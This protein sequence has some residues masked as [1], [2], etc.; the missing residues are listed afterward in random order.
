MRLHP[1]AATFLLAGTLSL[2]AQ[3]PQAAAASASHP[4]ADRHCSADKATP[5]AGE[6]ALARK[7]YDAALTFYRAA[8]AQDRNSQEARFGLVLALIGKDQSKEAVDEAAASVALEPAS[9]LA[10]VAAGQAAYRAADFDGALHDAVQALK[11]GPCE[12]RA[13]QLAAQ[14]YTIHAYF[15][16][17]AS[18]LRDA[19]KL[20]PNDELIR[21]DW[22][23]SLPRS[24]RT[25]ELEKYL[26]G[27]NALSA[28][29][30]ADYT[31]EQDHLKDRHP[32]ECRITAKPDSTKIPFIPI[33]GDNPHP[34]AFG[35]EVA[36]NSK[37]RHM[38]IDTGASGIVLTPFGRQRPR[39][40]PRIPH[41]HRWRWR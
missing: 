21:R 15:Q 32:G 33:Y 23:D 31:V 41:P 9:P 30:L 27:P 13:L 28:K 8:V 22:I 39:P 17:A 19:H 38:Q 1:L 34:V 29:D 14:L 5:T 4:P 6:L 10:Q 24:Q 35:L 7:D 3:T 2:S 11:A 26:S 20:R 25:A 16:T 37:K 36:F 12:A 18:L 40:H